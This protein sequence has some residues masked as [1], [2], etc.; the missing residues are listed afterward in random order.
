MNNVLIRA[1]VIAL[2]CA[3]LTLSLCGCGQEIITRDPKP[4]DF[5]PEYVVKCKKRADRGDA[6]F[7]EIYGRA[8]HDGLGIASNQEESVIWLGK[9]AEQGNARS[10]WALGVCYEF[11]TGVGKDVS[12]AVKWYQRAAEQGNA[13]GQRA[14]GVCYENGKGVEKN[15]ARAVE[16]Y[17]K[18]AEQG[19]A[20]GQ[21]FLGLCY[22]K[23][24]GVAKDAAKAVECYRKAGEQGD[25][26]GQRNIGWCYASGTG[27]E[28]DEALAVDWYTKSANQG[29]A[30]AER[31]LSFCYAEGRGV[32]KDESKSVELMRHSAEHG[33]SRAQFVL[34][35]WNEY[36]LVGIKRDTKSAVNL[37][38]K[39]VGNGCSSGELH[40]KLGNLFWNG[41][42]S[43]DFH[44][45]EEKAIEHWQ[46]AADVGDKGAKKLYEAIEANVGW[47][48]PFDHSSLVPDTKIDSFAGFTF[49]GGGISEDAAARLGFEKTE[50]MHLVKK[51]SKKNPFRKMDGIELFLTPKTRETYGVRLF[52][53]WPHSKFDS[54][55][56]AFVECIA[57]R[58]TITR[59][60]GVLPEYQAKDKQNDNVTNGPWGAP[61]NPVF[62]LPD[63]FSYKWKLE[64][65]TIV[66][67][68]DG[69]DISL[70]A[71]DDELAEIAE[72]ERKSLLKQ[73]KE[74]ATQND[75]GDML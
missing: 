15:E 71:T 53:E 35:R 3:V 25:A 34:G 68:F 43:S 60:Y 16:W 32:G 54:R 19:D 55:E 1:F 69:W 39:A 41:A 5:T 51:G 52:V 48:A 17:R 38:L 27:V 45:D 47:S 10:M 42:P 66:L 18:A 30:I 73:A 40:Y 65:V 28:K 23:G 24:V 72:N 61:S 9:A 64:G 49:G 29:D 57:T 6:T 20:K 67:S 8:L 31:L 44:R 50:D 22:E 12:K 58:E 56:A 75:G 26:W 14:V 11:G 36:G 33:D 46:K 74:T 63:S 62:E 2:N 21:I 13:R 59:R 70:M 37:Y 4:E 7:Q